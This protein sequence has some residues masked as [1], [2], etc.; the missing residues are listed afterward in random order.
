MAQ[1][2]GIIGYGVLGSYLFS[3]ISN[4]PEWRIEFVYDEDKKK[5][6]SIDASQVID[7]MQ[8]ARKRRVD[9]VVEVASADWVINHSPFVLEFSDLLIY[10]VTAFA[11]KG[12]KE[13]L[14][15]IAR[16]NKTKYYISHGAIVGLDGVRDGKSLITQVKITTIKHPEKLGLKEKVA[17]KKIVYEGPTRR[18]CELYPRNVNVHASLALHGLGFDNTISQIVAD[19]A[20]TTM[21]HLIEIR[22]NGLSWK[23]DLESNPVGEVTGSY[24]PESVLQTLKRLTGQHYGMNLI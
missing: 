13:Q 23:I 22:G 3:K 17:E 11:R 4:D 12:L 8:Q 16:E 2:I 19:P 6:S 20:A 15:Q 18:A 24:T 21:R 1:K 14:D 10:S 7:S 9:L 5:V